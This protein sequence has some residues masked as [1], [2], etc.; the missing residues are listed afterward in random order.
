MKAFKYLQ[1]RKQSRATSFLVQPLLMWLLR[2]LI[3]EM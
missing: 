3:R 1:K 2:K